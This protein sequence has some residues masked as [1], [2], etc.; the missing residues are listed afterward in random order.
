MD[1]VSPVLQNALKIVQHIPGNVALVDIRYDP[2]ISERIGKEISQSHSAAP[3]AHP[4][5][6][7]MP[8]EAG[9]SHNASLSHKIVIYLSKPQEKKQENTHSAMIS[10][11]G[12]FSR[13]KP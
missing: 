2:N 11:S 13:V 7:R 1:K 12:Q 6:I 8:G 4:G 9:N 10:P 5:S 3:V